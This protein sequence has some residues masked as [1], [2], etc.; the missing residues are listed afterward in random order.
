MADNRY[1]D[2][3]ID[4]EKI[5]TYVGDFFTEERDLAL[6]KHS[7]INEINGAQHRIV[8]E[9]N[10]GKCSLDFYYKNNGR[11]T[12]NPYTGKDQELSCLIADYIIEASLQPEFRNRSYVSSDIEETVLTFISEALLENT[13]VKLVEES[14]RA[15]EIRYKFHDTNTGDQLTL[16]YY[17]TKDK[18][19]LQGKPYI[20]FHQ[21]MSV[22]NEFQPNAESIIESQNETY[23]VSISTH[24]IQDDLKKFI[25]ETRN[26]LGANQ[27]NII[28]GALGLK[29]LEIAL[30]DYSGFVMPVYRALE[31]LI[32]LLLKNQSISIEDKSIGSFFHKYSENK[33]ILIKEHRDDI[34]SEKV[35]NSLGV[36]YTY[37]KQKRHSL[38]H[39]QELDVFETVIQSKIDADIEV[40]E[41]LQLMESE[42]V[43]IKNLLN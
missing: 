14:K 36:L 13:N 41:T 4:K 20:L 10:K 33:Y 38:M 21:A 1:K 27:L 29:Q 26:F 12:I 25:P 40:T 8:I 37:Y 16:F 22:V 23:K 28:S 3:L 9:T 24:E 30:P 34:G 19:L 2:K 42:F 11:T 18:I 5:C 39:A 15:Y 17:S 32:K 7:G 6:V 31:A 35:C 43:K